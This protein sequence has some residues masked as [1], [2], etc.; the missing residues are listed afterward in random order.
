MCFRW[1]ESRKETES[2]FNIVTPQ[3]SCEP[4]AP[5]N[6]NS[7][8]VYTPLRL[9]KAEIPTQARFEVPPLSGPY[10]VMEPLP[11]AGF[12]DIDNKA[13]KRRQRR[14]RLAALRH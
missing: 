2:Y 7:R 8:L 4:F 1:H 3:A 14:R 10:E 12:V 11:G 13:M 6:P 9:D 5:S